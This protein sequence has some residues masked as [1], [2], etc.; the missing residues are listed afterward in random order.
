VLAVATGP[1]GSGKTEEVCAAV[2][3]LLRD[4]QYSDV[5]VLVLVSTLRQIVPL[6]ERMQLQ[7]HQYAVKV[8]T[9]P[10]NDELNNMGLVGLQY[11]EKDKARAHHYAQV[12][13]TTQAKLKHLTTEYGRSYKETRSSSTVVR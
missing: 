10:E 5:G 9:D 3:E 2:R 11:T 4:P 8:G 6:I 13:F 1:T 7:A 12:M